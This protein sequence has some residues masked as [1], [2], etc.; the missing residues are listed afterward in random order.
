[1]FSADLIEHHHDHETA[2][3]VT[4]TVLLVLSSS[5]LALRVYT[6]F[7]ITRLSALDDYLLI[8]AQ[9]VLVTGCSLW[10]KLYASAKQDYGQYSDDHLEYLSKVFLPHSFWEMIRHD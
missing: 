9:L 6:R 8:W 4:L 1:M 7:F 5:V 10:L 3:T 2:Y